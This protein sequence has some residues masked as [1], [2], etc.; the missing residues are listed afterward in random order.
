MRSYG[1][2]QWL[3]GAGRSRWNGWRPGRAARVS[4]E[5]ELATRLA[6]I[7]ESSA[8]SIVSAT[9]DGVI[10]TWNPA[11]ER[12]YGWA[13]GEII[14]RSTSLL[15]SPD[16]ADQLAPVFRRVRQGELIEPFETRLL[17][18]DGTTIEVW[19]ADSPIRDASGAVI[20]VSAITRDVTGRNRAEAER[21]ALEERLRQ[22]ERLESL[23]HL[24]GGIAH[25]FNNLLAAIMSFAAF[26]AEET[27]D[28]PEMAADAAQIQDAA[29]RAAQLTRQ[30]LI[31]SRREEP[32]LQILDL[33]AIVAG[34]TSLLSRTIGGNVQLIAGPAGNLP[35]IEADRG[36]VEQVLLN[37]AIN[38]RDAMPGGGTLTITT[39]PAD[40][41][42]GDPRLPAGGS[43]GRYAE[44]AV[45]DT[46]TGMSPQTAARIFEPFFTTKPPGQGTGLG[47]STVY[48]IITGAGGSLRVESEQGA[49]S[50]FRLY[51]PAASP[52][53]A[54]A[55][56]AAP[57]A[58]RGHGETI[59]V[60]DDEP[61]VLEAT[62]RIL[63]R[64]GYAAL[65]AATHEEALTLAASRDIQLLLTDSV[66]P[67]MP[68]TTLA[69]QIVRLRP[70][71]PVVY[72]S[73]Y[74]EGLPGSPQPSPG[75]DAPL[76]Y[77]PFDQQTLLE[78]VHAALSASP[79][80]RP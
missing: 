5:F 71:L 68:G 78:A 63:R 29:Q 13:A 76:I 62:A 60:V 32:Q 26:V 66:M 33:N 12:M 24:A 69:G 45:T 4:R 79:R 7:V 31:F 55:D 16:L 25:D 56:P 54:Q 37:L 39:S 41:P 80:P 11:A 22:S 23:G 40:L 43:P 58:A 64:H 15:I 42:G 9:L 49:G 3:P 67:R 65:E 57:P 70:G 6:A 61:A 59:L 14:G 1:T 30:L 52:A 73:G 50:T 51:F 48:G 72:M 21:R 19:L 10:T 17:R 38:A 47:L 53:T 36:Q 18:K 34:I 35:A 75:T 28:L 46:G 20:G 8:D 74:T 2:G 77:K 27:A 44:L